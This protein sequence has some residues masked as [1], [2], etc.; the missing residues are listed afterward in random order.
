[1]PGLRNR[2]WLLYS[3][4]G[5]ESLLLPEWRGAAGVTPVVTQL[6]TVQR[7]P[8]TFKQWDD[9]TDVGESGTRAQIQHC[10]KDSNC[11]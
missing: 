8:Q 9:A 11:K 10:R 2:V 1:M 4:T 6:A 5:G 3:C 7:A